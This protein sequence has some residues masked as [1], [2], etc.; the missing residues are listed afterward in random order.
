MPFAGGPLNLDF[1]G[2]SKV[3]ACRHVASRDEEAAERQF[4]G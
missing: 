3:D 1:A 2:L 4:E